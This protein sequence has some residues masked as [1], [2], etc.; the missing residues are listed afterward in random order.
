MILQ[1]RV[2]AAFRRDQLLCTSYELSYGDRGVGLHAGDDVGV[3]LERERRAFVAEA[4]ADDLRR[5]ASSQRDRGV[6]VA[7]AVEVNS[8][9]VDLVDEPFKRL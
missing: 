3:L 1:L 6:G 7:E 4:F 8:R 5:N 9:K 2:E